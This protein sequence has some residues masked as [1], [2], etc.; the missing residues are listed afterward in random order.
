MSYVKAE[1]LVTVVRLVVSDDAPRVYDETIAFVDEQMRLALLT[2]S[3]VLA[4]DRGAS[5]VSAAAHA[6]V[7]LD[8][9]HFS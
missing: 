7:A 8:A 9:R 6:D 3:A 2:P 1:D 4:C 5:Y